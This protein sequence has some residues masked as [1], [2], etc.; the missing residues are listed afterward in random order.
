M[1]PAA[2][3][4]LAVLRGLI[5]AVAVS[6]VAWVVVDGWGVVLLA[7]SLLALAAYC[8]LLAS[9]RQEPGRRDRRTA[10][11][12]VSGARHRDQRMA[13]GARGDARTR[14]AADRVARGA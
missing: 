8:A 4:R 2:R 3:R 9:V 11:G 12:Q 13:T 10:A 7:G 1:T 6:V 5:G 14:P